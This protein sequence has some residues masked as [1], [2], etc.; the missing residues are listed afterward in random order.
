[1]KV[2]AKTFDSISKPVYILEETRLRRNLHL[3]GSVAE[4]AGV[5]IILAFKAYAL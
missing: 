3:I 2:D 5:E 1:M 4:R